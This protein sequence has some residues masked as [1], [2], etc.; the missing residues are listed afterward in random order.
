M[1]P[2][3]SRTTSSTT[4]SF[5]LLWMPPSY[6]DILTLALVQT[7]SPQQTA[8]KNYS[9][10]Q[11][12]SSQSH[13]QRPSCSLLVP[14]SGHCKLQTGRKG[15]SLSGQFLLGPSL[16]F[17]SGTKLTIHCR[18]IPMWQSRSTTPSVLAKNCTYTSRV[19]AI[20]L[21]PSLCSKSMA[22][23]PSSTPVL[24]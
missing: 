7:H 22:L 12:G 2:L 19:T 23:G 9:C 1:S 11:H 3:G 24:P 21:A 4:F 13:S 6:L 20:P 18:P 14:S 16:P 17:L 5:L 10:N 8:T 15:S